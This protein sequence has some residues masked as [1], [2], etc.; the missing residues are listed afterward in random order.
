MKIIEANEVLNLRMLLSFLRLLPVGCAFLINSKPSLTLI[1]D[2]TF[3]CVGRFG[4]VNS[5]VR[6]ARG[7]YRA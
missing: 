7:G 6:S 4:I 1:I 2:A 3:C 5:R